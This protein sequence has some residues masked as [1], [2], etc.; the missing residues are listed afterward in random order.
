MEKP[1]QVN[2]TSP[3]NMGCGC[4][5]NNLEPICGSDGLTYISPCHA[6]CKRFAQNGAL[7]NLQAN[8]SDCACITN[9]LIATKAYEISVKPL[10]TTGACPR[11][12]NMLVP[13][14]VL[15]FMM[16][17]TISVAQMPILM[18]TMRT[19]AVEERSLAIGLQFVFFRLLGNFFGK[20]CWNRKFQEI[21][22]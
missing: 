13:F 1:F 8:F 19:V 9:E 15:V 21:P 4:S 18:L 10:A 22:V 5:E 6:G 20:L 12:C 11:Q 14:I 17:F 3:C 7:S 16:S 2:L